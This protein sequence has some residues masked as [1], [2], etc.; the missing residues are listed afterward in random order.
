MLEETGC[1]GIMV[2]RASRGNPWIFSE[3]NSYLDTGII[4]PRP[5]VE[6]LCN[7]ILKHARLQLQ[8]KDEYIAIR[9][10]R[11]HVAWYTAGYPHSAKIRQ[12]VNEIESIEELEKLI[13]S[14]TS[15]R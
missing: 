1:D 13:E 8:Y 2:G 14:L 6:E 9:E 7:T 15:S 5:T 10:M 11:K 4:P 12:A 3:I